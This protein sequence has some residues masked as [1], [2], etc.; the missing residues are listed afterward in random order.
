[1]QTNHLKKSLTLLLAV[2]L[3]LTPT[4]AALA[5]ETPNGN[6]GGTNDTPL[7]DSASDQA[8]G[9]AEPDADE[10][11]PDKAAIFT[12]VKE[13]DWFYGDVEYV[14]A[15]GLLS[16]TSAE[17]F[18]PNQPMTRAMLVTALFRLA[19]PA[20]G[21]NTTGFSD[22]PLYQWYSDAVA[23]ATQNGIVT[24]YDATH[25]GPSDP[26]TREQAAAI[27]F[28]YAVHAGQ[29]PQGSWAIRLDF[30]DLDK[31]SDYAVEAVMFCYL[32]D[33]INGKPD[34]AGTTL[35]DPTAN[36]T[37]AEAAATLHRFAA[38]VAEARSF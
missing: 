24:G 11:S 30:A 8:Q 36:A 37:R 7:S 19:T 25:F 12:D 15:Q 18:S 4:F 21:A 31:I 16:G 6:S 3:C 32:S 10:N 17:T 34:V 23:W 22:V 9:T 1:M 2:I 5:A 35:F 14:L 27:L 33:I 26:V 29:G 38:N 28:R 13:S 20:K